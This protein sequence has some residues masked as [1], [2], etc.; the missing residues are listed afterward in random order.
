MFSSFYLVFSLNIFKDHSPF[1]QRG[2]KDTHF[3][4]LRKFFLKYFY[5]FLSPPLQSP[6]SRHSFSLHGAP[7]APD[8][9][10]AGAFW[11]YF[12]PSAP[13]IGASGAVAPEKRRGRGIG[14]GARGRPCP[15]ERE[16]PAPSGV[17]GM[18][19]SGRLPVANPLPRRR[20]KIPDQVG[21]DNRKTGDEGTDIFC[22]FVYYIICI[23][24]GKQS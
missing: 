11:A 5:F 23:E 19:Q 21:D 3:L 18:E 6:L 2:C 16:G 4:L 12:A 22:I 20:G 9:G 10:V 1:F 24:Y 7:G 17:G 15:R 13:T 8:A 14:D